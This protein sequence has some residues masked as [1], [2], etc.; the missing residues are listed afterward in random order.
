M[1]TA[2]EPGTR[3]YLA[4]IPKRLARQAHDHGWTEPIIGD[5][6]EWK[7]PYHNARGIDASELPDLN[8][9]K[10]EIW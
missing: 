4:T 5:L 8:T 7:L 10:V 3:P 6:H 2:L 9:L 1:D